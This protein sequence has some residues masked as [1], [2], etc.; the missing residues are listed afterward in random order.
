MKPKHVLIGGHSLG[1]AQVCVHGW[2]WMLC[3]FVCECLF[4]G[5][6][7]R[8]IRIDISPLPP[9]SHAPIH[10]PQSPPP[11]HQH[12]QAVMHGYNLQMALGPDVRV[13]MLAVVRCCKFVCIFEGDVLR[14]VGVWNG[15]DGY[16][17][18]G[19]GRKEVYVRWC[20]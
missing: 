20:D 13:D 18:G 1:G 2:I 7:V 5:P 11:T 16:R 17:E 19:S 3:V 8:P 10:P 14:C 4:D 12:T 15:R 6:T 9:Q